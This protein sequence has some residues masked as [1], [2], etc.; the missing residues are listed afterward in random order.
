MQELGGIL[1]DPALVAVLQRFAAA[2]DLH[3]IFSAARA[4]SR[5]QQAAVLALS[6]ISTTVSQQ[7]M[8][9]VEQYLERKGQHVSSISFVGTPGD[10]A[11]WRQVLR[12][13][14]DHSSGEV[15]TK[16]AAALLSAE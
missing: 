9:S 1:P 12:L 4:H 3:S 16:A 5:L 11:V 7:Q 6:S 13:H 15:A 8:D 2:G 10:E 14:L